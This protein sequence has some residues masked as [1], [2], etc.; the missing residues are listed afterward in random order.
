MLRKLLIVDGNSLIHR[1]FHAIPHL[2]T[3]SGEPTNGVYGFALLFLKAIKELKPD[4]VVVTF[5]FPGPT[6]R[7]QIFE[8]Y[9]AHR[10]KAPDDLYAQIPTFKKMVSVF[11]LP[12]YEMQRYEADDIIGTLATLA[13]KNPD[14]ETIILT[15]DKDAL[16][17]IN[18][19]V[20]VYMPK[21]GLSETRLYD[22]KAVR[23]RFGIDS[24]QFIDYKALR[25]DPSDN[26]PGVKGIGDIT[27]VELLQ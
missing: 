26:I 11:N 19:R 14:L 10:V 20:K 9:K 12:V 5:D 4:Y 3:K 8:P 1:R 17:L 6:F 7:E 2:S 21:Q 18:E 24:S 22:Q 16:Q 27:A 15:G 13:Q 25:G 23:D